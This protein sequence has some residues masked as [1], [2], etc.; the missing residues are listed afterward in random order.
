M[1]SEW[2]L[3]RLGDVV[4]LTTGFP[5]ASQQ[6]TDD[7]TAPRLLRGDNVGQ[8]AIRWDGAK[9]W[10][11]P[12]AE[13]LDAY[14]LREGDVILAMDRPWIEAGLK[15]AYVRQSDLPALLVQR[16]ARLRGSDRLD[17]GFLRYVIAGRDF[18]DYVTGIQTGTAVPHISGGQIHGY[19]FP[20][21]P[22]A[23]QRRIAGIL[24]TLDDKIELNRCMSQALESMAFAAYRN[25]RLRSRECEEQRLSELVELNPPRSLASGVRAPYLDMANMPTSG[26]SAA[27]VVTRAVGSGMRFVNGDTLMARIT[28]CLE[29]GKAAFVDFLQ[30]GEVGWGSTE[31]IVLRPKGPLPV[32]FAYCLVREPAFVEFAVARMS[33][34]SGRQR[35][36]AASLGDYPLRVEMEDVATFA[37]LVRPAFRRISSIARENRQLASLRNTLLPV[38]LAARTA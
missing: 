36:S 22:L 27:D 6:Y 11:V 7:P 21:P 12:A 24:G 30:E 10:P 16:V 26:P 3:V 5:F 1:G 13:G 14:W 17:T 18:T 38:L 19:Q 25:L 8:G 2:P 23:E 29:N 4:D 37:R 33:G 9:R 31:Y 20:L 28:P 34:T 35:V 15:Y 32:E